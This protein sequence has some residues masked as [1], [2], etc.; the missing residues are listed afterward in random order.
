MKN[1]KDFIKFREDLK[2]TFEIMLYYDRGNISEEQRL[3]DLL[4]CLKYDINKYLNKGN[5]ANYG[6]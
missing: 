1:K 4:T 5:E 6:K 3:S 2:K